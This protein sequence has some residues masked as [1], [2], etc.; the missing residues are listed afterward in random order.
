MSRVPSW[1]N[2]TAT[3]FRVARRAGRESGGMP[4][5]ETLG[6]AGPLSRS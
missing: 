6:S 2:L 5:S 1:E 3:V 4:H